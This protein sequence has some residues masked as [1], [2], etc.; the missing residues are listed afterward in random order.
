MVHLAIFRLLYHHLF[1]SQPTPAGLS[2]PADYEHTRKDLPHPITQSDQDLFTA[3][4][5][6]H[7]TGTGGNTTRILHPRTDPE[8]AVCMR[9]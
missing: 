2:T 4:S 9:R 6:N 7:S 5:H 3:Q 8:N 1:A